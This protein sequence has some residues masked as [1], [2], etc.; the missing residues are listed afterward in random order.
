MSKNKDILQSP[1]QNNFSTPKDYFDQLPAAIMNRI[2]SPKKNP[3]LGLKPVH[4]L[5]AL[6]ISACII[7]YTFIFKR[8]AVPSDIILSENEVE[9]VIA[10]PELYN[11]DAATV[12]EYLSL[13][14]TDKTLSGE[15]IISDEEIKTYLAENEE[16]THIINEY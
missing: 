11:L 1:G 9:H 3:V 2:H 6:A 12:T 16:I 5:A 7:A 13:N 8:S 4:A 14:L 15:Y 10:N